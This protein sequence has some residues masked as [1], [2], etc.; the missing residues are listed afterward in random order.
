MQ[1]VSKEHLESVWTK[2]GLC[3]ATGEDELCLCSLVRGLLSTVLG[4][5]QAPLR[6][7]PKPNTVPEITVQN[8]AE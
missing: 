4:E 3:E 7:C 8:R 6:V 2:E 5:M 1:S